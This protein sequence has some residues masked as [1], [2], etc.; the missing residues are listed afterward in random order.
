MRRMTYQDRLE[1]QRRWAAGEHTL[2]IAAETGFSQTTI[3][4]EL[5]RGATGELDEQFRPVYS[6]ARGQETYQRNLRNC[7]RQRRDKEEQHGTDA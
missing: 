1:L 2:K 3:Y 6:A 7:G 4:K 5:G